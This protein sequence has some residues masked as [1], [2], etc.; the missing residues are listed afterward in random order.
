MKKGS[1]WS[2]TWEKIEKDK[3]IKKLNKKII[4]ILGRGGKYDLSEINYTKKMSCSGSIIHYIL[5]YYKI[6]RL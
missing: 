3:G 5:N 6:E 4:E 2:N 1:D